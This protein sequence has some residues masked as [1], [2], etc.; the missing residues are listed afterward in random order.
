MMRLPTLAA[1][2]AVAAAVGVSPVRAA[3]DPRSETRVLNVV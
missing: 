1:L 2:A 3:S